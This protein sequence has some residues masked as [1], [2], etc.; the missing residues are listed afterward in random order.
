M[1]STDDEGLAAAK[2]WWN[3]NGKPLLTGALLAGVVV[4]GWQ[5]WHKY[6]ANQSQGASALYQA[7]LETSLTPDGKPDA[8][9]VASF[10]ASSR[11]SSAAPPTPSTAACSSPRWRSRA[12]SWTTRRAN[13]KA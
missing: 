6:Q 10:P 4:M 11:A 7:L 1:S 5:T 12:A 8:S 2:D 3:R 13:S 9:K